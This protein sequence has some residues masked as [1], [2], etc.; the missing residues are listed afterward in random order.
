M[1]HPGVKERGKWHTIHSHDI[2]QRNGL[3]HLRI[4]GSWWSP[5][6]FSS[7]S[8]YKYTLH[9]VPLK[10]NIRPVYHHPNSAFKK[11]KNPS[12]GAI[13]QCNLADLDG[14]LVSRSFHLADSPADN[15]HSNHEPWNSGERAP[16]RKRADRLWELLSRIIVP[17]TFLCRWLVLS[18]GYEKQV[19]Q[20]ANVSTISHLVFVFFH[21]EFPPPP[22]QNGRHRSAA[23]GN[24]SKFNATAE[25]R[26]I[27]RPPI[28]M[29]HS[30]IRPSV[31]KC[32]GDW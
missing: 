13:F 1:S 20:A 28:N 11:K 31:I 17:V 2:E 19:S 22:V 23:T 14:F 25:Q 15:E 18:A 5:H 10:R 3:T 26:P 6:V 21:D 29:N 16:F 32:C 24:W 7:L 9:Y 8:P 12:H 27:K 30:S 4:D